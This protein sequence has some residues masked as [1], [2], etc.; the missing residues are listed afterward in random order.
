MRKNQFKGKNKVEPNSYDELNSSGEALA[1]GKVQNMNSP[2]KLN[3]RNTYD[4]SIQESK[5]NK[6]DDLHH[7]YKEDYQPAKYSKAVEY[8]N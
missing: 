7:L 3:H 5:Q 2:Q 4:D 6:K 1:Y 8:R